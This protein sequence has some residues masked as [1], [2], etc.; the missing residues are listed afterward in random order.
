[1]VR[2]FC[3]KSVFLNLRNAENVILAN[4]PI[5]GPGEH[6]AVSV[7]FPWQ[8]A[9]EVEAVQPTL[10]ARA[11]IFLPHDELEGSHSDHSPHSCQ[12]PATEQDC[13]NVD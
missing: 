4:W 7:G 13:R 1:M 8:A 2:L 9:A 11:L 6:G 10:Q 5:H 3:F 12:T